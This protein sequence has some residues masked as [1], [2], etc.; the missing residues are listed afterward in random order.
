MLIYGTPGSG[1]NTLLRQM[2]HDMYPRIAGHLV[3]VVTSTGIVNSDQYDWLPSNYIKTD[4]S[5]LETIVVQCIERQVEVIKANESSIGCQDGRERRATKGQQSGGKRK[6]KRSGRDAESGFDFSKAAKSRK[7]AAAQMTAWMS[8]GKEK[9]LD[10]LTREL[11]NKNPIPEEKLDTL[12]EIEIGDPGTPLEKADKIL[13]ILDDCCSEHAIR[14]SSSI[15]QWANSHRHCKMDGFILSQSV[16]GSNGPPPGVRANANF[17]AVCGHYQDQASRKM[18]AEEYLTRSDDG[19]AKALGLA[20]LSDTVCEPHRCL[21]I[22]KS[23]WAENELSR[24]CYAYGP[25]P[26]P[27]PFPDWRLGLDQQWDDE[28]EQGH[29]AEANMISKKPPVRFAGG[30]VGPES[31][32]FQ[33][34]RNERYKMINPTGQSL[35]RDIASRYGGWKPVLKMGQQPP[36]LRIPVYTNADLQF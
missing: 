19:N 27:F 31:N 1:K 4:I 22:E 7:K 5:Q 3:I 18:L 21:V 9:S 14:Y 15:L 13:L 36:R 16:R 26:F 32:F 33:Q 8:R 29:D 12:D 24:Y 11:G 2:L 6:R 17:I 20:L 35:P 34:W 23:P 30:I 28:P 25:V 10:E